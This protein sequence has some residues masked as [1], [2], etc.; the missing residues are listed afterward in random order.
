MTTTT[1][2]KLFQVCLQACKSRVRL[3]IEYSAIVWDPYVV[4]NIQRVEIIQRRAARWV[5]GRYDRLDSVTDML[6]S[7]KWRSLE[8]RRSDAS[9][10][11]LYKQSN[12]L[13]S[14]ECDKP[15]KEHKRQKEYQVLVS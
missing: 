10:C 4:K 6:S 5:L 9:L 1:I 12:G 15:Q 14:Y 7:L 8:L 3:I 13:A 2:A 11:M